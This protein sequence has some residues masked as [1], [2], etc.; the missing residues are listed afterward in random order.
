MITSIVTDTMI[1]NNWQEIKA[2]GEKGMP[3]LFPI[4]VI[5]EHGPHLPLG[6]D[7]YW[8]ISICKMVKEKLK[9]EGQECMIAPPFYWGVDNYVRRK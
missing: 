6:A 3:T 2:A 8:S 1:A 7:I 4:G 9:S 5:E